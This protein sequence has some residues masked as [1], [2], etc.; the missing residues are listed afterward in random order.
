MVE[1][2]TP[3][4]PPYV[5]CAIH[6]CTQINVIKVFNGYSKQTVHKKSLLKCLESK[7]PQ[8]MPIVTI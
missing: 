2:Q 1:E 4:R 5:R 7:W 3:A 8:V 6:S